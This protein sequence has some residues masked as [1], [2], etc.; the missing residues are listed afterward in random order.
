MT[1]NAS[2]NSSKTCWEIMLLEPAGD[3]YVSVLKHA[4]VAAQ[5]LK[6]QKIKFIDA[7]KNLYNKA[8]LLLI[9]DPD[10][11]LNNTQDIVAWAS[12]T[13]VQYK[14]EGMMLEFANL[15]DKMMFILRWS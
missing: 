15:E 10:W 3:R 4:N 14:R 5:L 13:S 2:W 7:K 9:T 1:Y 11:Y 12:E 6:E 8:E